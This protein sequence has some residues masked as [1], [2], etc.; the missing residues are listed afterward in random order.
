[1]G[2]TQAAPPREN[3][4][5]GVGLPLDGRTTPFLFR[6]CGDSALESIDFY[7][8]KAQVGSKFLSSRSQCPQEVLLMFPLL[9]SRWFLSLS[10]AALG[11]IG[12]SPNLE[13]NP[14]IQEQTARL[15]RVEDDLKAATHQVASVDAEVQLVSREVAKVSGKGPGGTLDAVKALEQRVALLEKRLAEA[16]VKP[17]Q[18]PV[19]AAPTP[20]APNKTVTNVVV[21]KG[22]VAKPGLQAKPG[23]A[24]RVIVAGKAVTTPK[25]RK[26]PE[27]RADGATA[28]R[29]TVRGTYHL[30][31]RGDTLES[32]AA[33]YHGSARAIMAANHLP[34][35]AS[36]VIGQTI[37]VPG[38]PVYPAG[39]K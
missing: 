27:R 2:V 1:M 25:T 12:C 39:T 30:V 7:L 23:D 8:A 10:L 33:K 29:R 38:Q 17:A 15:T 26:K 4:G 9:R 21:V 11:A 24:K 37:Y 16:A 3:Q 20:A 34:D 31:A 14:V 32:I 13:Q 6:N 5:A 35:S 19:A 22:T 18:M 36:L 28:A